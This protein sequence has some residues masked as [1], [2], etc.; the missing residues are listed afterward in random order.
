MRSVFSDPAGFPILP[1]GTFITT[2][3]SPMK[4]RWGGW[5]VT[6]THGQ[7][8]HLGNQVV[9]D[10]EHAESM[11]LS[12]GA[13]IKDLRA[14]IET[15]TYPVRHSDIVALMV[16]EH[17]GHVQN[18]ITRANYQT[19]IALD[20][21][22]AL[23]KELG[24][25][26]TGHSE[27][28]L[29]RVKSV[30]EPLTQALLFVK[31]APLTDAVAGTSGFAAEFAAQGPKDLQ[32]RSL[33]ELDLKRRLFRYPC[34]YLIYSEAF[35]ALPPLAKEYVYRRLWQVLNGEEKGPEFAHLTGADRKAVLEILLETKPD[36]AQTVKGLQDGGPA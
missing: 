24:R 3:Q 28:T 19:R 25:K 32:G 23:N 1:A 9:R 29:S 31:E 33:R 21:E 16:I 36:F 8:L 26:L 27:S 2:D 14:F 13:N 11:D 6:G 22:Q 10:V 5:Y 17:Q 12:K 20:Y 7:Q 4:E 30:A 15:S 34:S 18:L 35:D